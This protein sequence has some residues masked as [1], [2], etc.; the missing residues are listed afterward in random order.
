MLTDIV[1]PKN[2][3]AE[4]IQIALKL[5]LKKI[6]FL[7]DFN[8]YYKDEIQKKMQE[9][10][11]NKHIVIGT[12][13]IVNHKN[14]NQAWQK[15]KLL[16]AKSSDKDRF[17]M[18]SKKIKIIYGF[19]DVSRKDRLSQR[20]SWLNHTICELANENKVHIGFTY[21]PLL[22]K[23]GRAASLIIGRMMQNISLC[24]KYK[25]RILIASFANNPFQMRSSHDI[26]SLF[27]L[28]GM[29]REYCKGR[30]DTSLQI[31][32]DADSF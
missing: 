11:N 9:F 30:F 1:L 16:V 17:L 13:F 5:K 28:F 8:D 21:G 26:S 7:Y 23:S 29:S 32:R 27:N 3:E 31:Y 25:T 22:N 6:Y 2:N 19:E 18:E 4:F 10:E 15:S 12:G 24:Q 14:F 20:A